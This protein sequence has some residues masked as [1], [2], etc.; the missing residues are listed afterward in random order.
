MFI[1]ITNLCVC[2]C[3]CVCNYKNFY[4]SNNLYE[5]ESETQKTVINF[6]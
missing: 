2:V 5:E 3:V 6:K 4:N 1:I